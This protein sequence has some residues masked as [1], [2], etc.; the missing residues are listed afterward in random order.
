MA[1]FLGKIWQNM[2][3]SVS[4]TKFHIFRKPLKKQR[5][6]QRFSL[7]PLFELSDSRGIQ[8][9]NL[10][11]RSQMLY[12]VELGSLIF[13]F[14]FAKVCLFSD[15]AKYFSMFFCGYIFNILK[16]LHPKRWNIEKIV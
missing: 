5:G 4:P 9:H 12:S 13:Y 8:T 16:N 6:F 11:I 14:A 10:L 2:A 7:V 3:K 15:I 1:R